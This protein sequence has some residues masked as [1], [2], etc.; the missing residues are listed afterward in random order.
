MI[1]LGLDIETIPNQLI[2]KSC[3]PAFDPDEVK[4]GN[5]KDPMKVTQKINSEKE[6]FNQSLTKQMSLDPALCQLC[7]FVGVKYDTD[8]GEIIS[9]TIIQ[10]TEDDE[11]DDLDAVTEAWG[12]IHS[13]YNERVPV[14]SF[15]GWSFDLPV[16]S[17]RAFLQDVSI[18]RGMFDRLMMRYNNQYHYDLMQILA[19]WDRQRW[20]SQDFYFRLFGL[21]DKSDFDGSM[22]FEAYQNGE[23]ERIKTYCRNEVVLMCELFERVEPWIKIKREGA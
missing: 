5:T 19:N 3:V 20:H 7:T 13:N 12:C 22:V 8:E 11:H 21:G 9:E 23:Y 4:L 2:P 14:V 16:L 17:M 18:E 1:I 15:N 6:K 10:L